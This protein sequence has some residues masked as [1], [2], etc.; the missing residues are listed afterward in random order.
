MNRLDSYARL[1]VFLL[2]C[3]AW[4]MEAQTGPPSVRFPES[5]SYSPGTMWLEW[6]AS[7]RTGFIRGF[8]VGHEDGYRQACT[9]AESGKQPASATT[10]F[11]PCLEKRH[12]FRQDVSHYKHYITD[13]YKQ[14]PEDRDVPVRILLMQADQ[15]TP[16]EVHQWLAK[17]H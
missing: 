9:V 14:Y 7:E 17:K 6:S 13:F 3:I 11:D 2:V 15:K 10:G 5:R 16:K 4:P 8:I 1:S 12:L